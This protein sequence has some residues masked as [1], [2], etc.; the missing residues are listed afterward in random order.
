[1]K[2]CKR[3]M[4]VLLA[5]VAA[6]SC[7][8]EA[9][10]PYLT[11]E[12]DFGELS[13]E[14]IVLGEKLDD[15]YSVENVTKALAVLYPTKADRVEVAETDYYVR[16]LPAD[17]D[18]YFRLVASGLEM[19]DHPLDYRIVRDG[20]WYHDPGVAED[21]IT[22]Q[23]AVVPRDYVF[24]Q[25]I[26]YEVLDRCYISEHDPATRAGGE[27]I[28]WE[29][30]EREAFR[31]TGNEDLLLPQTK[32]KAKPQGR[33]TVVDDNAN[34]GKAFGVSGVKVV[35]NS[36]V[37]FSSGYTDRD[38]YYEVSKKYSSKVRYRLLFK[39]EK[40]FAIGVN[41]ILI[42]A[43]MSALGKGPSEGLD[44]EI[45]KDSDRKLFTRCVVNNAVY[46]Y[47]ERCNED[48]MDLPCPPK[49]LRIWLFQKL[50]V[51]SACMLRQ[52][53]V[54]DH[55]V[56]KQF[57]G[58][59]GSLVKLFLPDITLGLKGAE[60][61]ADIYSITCHE[62]AH[63]SHFMQV[64]KDWW[65]KFIFYILTSYVSTGETYGN[66]SGE[67]AGHCAV[68]E[69]W[70]YYMQN[71]MFNDR[72][73]GVMPVAGSSYWFAPQ[74]LRYLDE[75]GMTRAEIFKAL[76]AD[77]ASAEALQAK[78]RTLYPDKTS[79]IDQVFDRYAK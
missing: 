28:D 55:S 51:S 14:Q 64:G 66:G 12:T 1:M 48:D 33:I 31:L 5:I 60:S 24:P 41:L 8:K 18:Q 49:N 21:D 20:D 43:S 23:Y 62:L 53:A 56:L 22:W 37:K 38:G 76:T 13:H 44:V 70:A 9:S 39:N 26:R 63:A 42:P 27:G 65:D 29:A 6:G 36:F 74:I 73:G 67:N 71:R 19:M 57:L 46:E 17:E 72:Y 59:Y 4:A 54:I 3:I 10:D 61:Y 78:L 34:G 52:G 47:L 25:D 75:R 45:T 32:A 16:F 35:C 79:L 11:D 58:E 50:K 68:G 40:G 77:V 7:Q 30:V 69:M 2:T 15:P